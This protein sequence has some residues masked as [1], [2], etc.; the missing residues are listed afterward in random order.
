MAD[1]TFRAEFDDSAVQAGIER[2]ISSV[3]KLQGEFDALGNKASKSMGEA[4]AATKVATGTA[5]KL[6]AGQKKAAVATGILTVA[7]RVLGTALKAIGIGLL[8]SAGAALVAAFTKA[9]PVTDAL[10]D[11]FSAMSNIVSTLIERAVMF[12]RGIAQIFSGNIKEGINSIS[13]SVDGLGASLVS[14]AKAGIETS[15]AL[16]SIAEQEEDLA[17]DIAQ[18]SERLARL[19]ALRDDDTKSIRERQA[20]AR[21]AGETER[22]FQVRNIQL[23]QERLK[24]ANQQADVTRQQRMDAEGN[25]RLTKEQQDI[26]IELGQ[27]Q[28]KLAEYDLDAAKAQAALRKEAA[29]AAK[30][31]RKE[32]AELQKQADA[33][34]LQL[35]KLRASQLTGI[36]QV[37]AER[38]LA[39]KALDEQEAALRKAFE[40]RGKAF[41]LEAEFEQARALVAERAS[42]QIRGILLEE[43]RERERI[44][45]R[46]RQAEGKALDEQRKER[47]KEISLNEQIAQ[48]RVDLIERAGE[49]EQEFAIQIA[50]RKLAIEIQAARQR[51]EVVA[52]QYGENSPEVLLARE[53]IRL[54]EREYEK[55]G[56]V[57]V[58]G[59]DALKQK[60]L[61]A[62][63]ITEA[64]AAQALQLAGQAINAVT[65][66]I[67]AGIDAQLEQQNKLIDAI[68][69]R[70]QETEGLLREE[71][72]RAEQG[73]A[74]DAALFEESLKKQQAALAAAEE[75]KARLQEQATK[76]ELKQNQIQAASEYALLVI[77]LISSQATKGIIGIGIALGG[78]ALVARI[79]AQQKAAAAKLVSLREGTEFVEG[80]GTG[81]SDS[82]PAWLS[83]GERVT[84]AEDNM[85]M[86]GRALSNSEMVRLVKLGRL[87]DSGSFAPAN[88]EARR[89]TEQIGEMRVMVDMKIAEKAY[90]EAANEAAERIVASV[91]ARPVVIPAGDVTIVE[92]KKGGVKS[93]D[94][95]RR[96]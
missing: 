9:K 91:E 77:R 92:R 28:G 51:L 56:E 47:L 59:F 87:V 24:V 41:T 34:L 80:P 68:R 39:L 46:S 22:E 78:L 64:E 67:D 45:E 8:I 93:R 82:I 4:A 52:G 11:A 85:E 26:L 27:A 40:E 88:A 81:T 71:Q 76:R 66:L 5:G 50:R 54:L 18:Q 37:R 63:G 89:D 49:T 23:L 16:R 48:A 31:R 7:T 73:Y 58:S 3:E 57:N 43:A 83:R 95:I 30:A 42:S 62:L 14:A 55:A 29:D 33:F 60:I 90:R 17:L 25:I 12:G 53:Q 79:I 6:E 86:G 38:A 72:R 32:L 65:G 84:S 20:A 74:N 69:S 70:I 94:I 61:S 19:K 10:S 1:V 15:R 96:K 13:A 44:Q 35:E 21:A 2:N 75:E 36:E